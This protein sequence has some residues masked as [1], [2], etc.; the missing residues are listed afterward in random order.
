[1]ILRIGLLIVHRLARLDADHVVEQPLGEH[2][3]DR[4]GA[5]PSLGKD[6]FLADAAHQVDGHLVALLHGAL[7]RRPLGVLLAQ[8]FDGLVDLGLVEGDL[9]LVLL[10]AM[11]IAQR[12]HGLHGDDRLEDQWLHGGHVQIALRVGLQLGLVQRFLIDLGA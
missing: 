7:D 1:M 6:L 3:G 11:I 4:F 9:R 5:A 10:D 2:G 12:H 8:L